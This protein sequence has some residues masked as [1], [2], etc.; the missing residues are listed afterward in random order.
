MR[1]EAYVPQYAV[2]R[3]DQVKVFVTHCGVNSISESIL[4]EVEGNRN[5]KC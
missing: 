2:L 4:N 3:H 5:I 1:V